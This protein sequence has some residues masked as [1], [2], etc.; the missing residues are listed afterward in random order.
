MVRGLTLAGSQPTP[1]VATADKRPAV[2]LERPTMA[3][4]YHSSVISE[5]SGHCHLP[6]DMMVKNVS[7]NGSFSGGAI[8]DTY[9]L[10]QTQMAAERAALNKLSAPKKF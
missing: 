2:S 3:K 9:S 7:G 6:T 8:D 4:R 5:T 1:Y 10:V